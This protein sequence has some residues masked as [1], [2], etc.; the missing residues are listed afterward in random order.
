[1]E[2]LMEIPPKGKWLEEVGKG[3]LRAVLKESKNGTQVCI[4]TKRDEWVWRWH[5]ATAVIW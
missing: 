5:N 1:M 4:I 2:H 3:E